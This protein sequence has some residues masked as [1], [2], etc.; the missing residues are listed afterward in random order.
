MEFRSAGRAKENN[1]VIHI[2]RWHT[3]T[4]AKVPEGRQDA[5]VEREDAKGDFFHPYGGTLFVLGGV[6]AMNR[7]RW[8]IFSRSFGTSVREFR[9]IFAQTT[10]QISAN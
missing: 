10:W 4:T 9:Q 8:A 1:P 3:V 5:L 7:N 2:H 6:P